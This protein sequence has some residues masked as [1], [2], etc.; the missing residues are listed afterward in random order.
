[1]GHC[2]GGARVIAGKPQLTRTLGFGGQLG[3]LSVIR[4]PR[5]GASLGLDPGNLKAGEM[6]PTWPE[7]LGKKGQR[8]EEKDSLSF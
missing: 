7:R 2:S 3:T 1:M 5:R 8:R 6:G 4:C